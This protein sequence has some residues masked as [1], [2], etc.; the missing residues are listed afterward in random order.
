M[1]C[2]E[3]FSHLNSQFKLLTKKLLTFSKASKWVFQATNAKTPTAPS[4]P[5]ASGQLSATHTESH[6][7]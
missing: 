1:I 3:T 4:S 2:P 5:K 6:R 7:I